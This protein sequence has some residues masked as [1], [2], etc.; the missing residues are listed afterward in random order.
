MLDY[1]KETIEAALKQRQRVSQQQIA[2]PFVNQGD[3][4]A[5]GDKKFL[6]GASWWHRW[7]DYVNFT[8][9]ELASTNRNCL[10]PKDSF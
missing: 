10:L 3:F 6:I 8:G 2:N 1:F 5:L 9:D 4:G 7:C